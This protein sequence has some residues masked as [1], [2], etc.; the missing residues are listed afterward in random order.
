VAAAGEPARTRE[1]PQVGAQIRRLRR[2]RSLTLAEVADRSGLNIGYLSQIE[3]DKASPSLETLAAL[4]AAIDVPITWFL[5]DTAAP[6]RVVRAADRRSWDGPGGGRVEEVD[7]GIPRDVRI[8]LANSA[9]GGRTGMH[10]HGGDEHHVVLSGRI[11]M[12]QGEHETVLGP[13]DY[14]VWDATIPHDVSTIGDEPAQILIVG[15]RAHGAE[16]SRPEG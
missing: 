14:L 12:V 11:R 1:R 13:G 16:T 4:A 9:P 15:H 3:N 5:A 10:A 2:E 8:V 6:P 7:G